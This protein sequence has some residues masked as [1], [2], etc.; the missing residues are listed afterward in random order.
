MVSMKSNSQI[1][2]FD[3]LKLKAIKNGSVQKL[4]YL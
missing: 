3:A 1:L 4:M 2:I